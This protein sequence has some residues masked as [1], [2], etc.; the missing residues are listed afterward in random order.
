MRRLF[1]IPVIL[2]VIILAACSDSD[3]GI[4]SP[5]DVPYIQL[6]VL[7]DSVVVDSFYVTEGYDGTVIPVYDG[8]DRIGGIEIN[9]REFI[10]D[11]PGA[12]PQMMFNALARKD[13]CYASFASTNEYSTISFDYTT[14]FKPINPEMNCGVVLAVTEDTGDYYSV[15]SYDIINV[16]SGSDSIGTIQV[17]DR[18][19]FETD[20][21]AGNYTITDDEWIYMY[22]FDDTEFNLVSGYA[23]YKIAAYETFADKP[24]I[25]L[26][27]TETTT[28]DVS[29][30][31]PHGGFVVA[32]DPQY[33]DLWQDITVEP[34]GRINDSFDYLF[35][36]A[37]I[38]AFSQQTCGW[39]V[40]REDLETFFTDNL[41]ETGFSQSEIDDFN[42]WWIPLLSDSE[43]YA[44]YPQYNDRIDP[45]IALEFSKQPDSVIRLFY[46]VDAIDSPDIKLEKPVIPFIE[47]NGFVVREWGVIP[48]RATKAQIAEE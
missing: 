34:N 30:D 42:E 45:V 25:Y 18:G 14:G 28:L 35:Y 17:D 38:L 22:G 13:G 29:I 1:C 12:E 26:Y 19:R 33:P 21:P 43:Y 9:L 2:I 41:R 44:I 7:M 20:I 3:G 36:E 16:W 46:Y 10:Y 23:E 11:Y 48:S 15:I 31:F 37:S 5:P 40:P 32:S 39:V 24:N 4:A 8:P 27:P 47:Q 6:F